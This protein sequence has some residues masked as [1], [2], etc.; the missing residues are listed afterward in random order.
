LKPKPPED[1]GEKVP[2]WIISFADMITLL[3]SFFVMLQTMAKSQDGTLFGASQ[4]SFRRAINGLG[5]PEIMLGKQATVDMD[6]QKLQYP[7]E[8][9]AKEASPERPRVIDADDDTIRQVFEDLKQQM[10]V[11]ADSVPEATIA[12]MVTPIRFEKGHFAL[13]P[14]DRE[15]LA[16]LA[17]TFRHDLRGRAAKISVIGLAGDEPDMHAQFLVSARRASAVRQVLQEKLG[18]DETKAAGWTMNAWGA[19]SGKDLCRQLGVEGKNAQV[20]IVITESGSS[21]GG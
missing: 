15:Y 16:G 9:T 21:H 14:S 18:A 17:I 10:D 7:A 2:L 19:G 20:V 5:F 11:Q 6:Y 3:L 13:T 8:E 1:S 12:R 4:E